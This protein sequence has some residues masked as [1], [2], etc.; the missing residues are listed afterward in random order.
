MTDYPRGFRLDRGF[1][2]FAYNNSSIDYASL[3]LVNALLIKKH[4]RTNAGALIADHNAM[5]HLESLYNTDVIR[6]AFDRIII[7][8]PTDINV[9]KRRFHDTRYTAFTDS[10]RNTN[11]ASVYD[12]SPFEET[13]L[14]D[15]DYLML[16]SSFDMV[17]GSVEDMMCNRHT[18]DL[19][20]GVDKFGFDNR[21]NEMSVPL[22]WA[23]AVYFRKTDRSRLIFE[24]MNFIKEN[25][26]YYQYLYRFNHS[27][28]FRND[29]AL[30]MALHMTN[31]LTEQDNMSALPVDHIMFSMEND[32]LHAFKDGC[33]LVT[34]EP[35]QGDF[36]IHNVDYNVHVM[37]KRA[38]LRLKDDIIAYALS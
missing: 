6:R 10:Y 36:R 9:G 35:N 2:M 21:F 14:I 15:S 33:C 38:I 19:D 8:E 34:S 31:N 18:R 25:Y 26:A 28:Y 29:Y 3:A 37:N 22:Y 16:D 13:L 24:L 27:G 30:S 7:D 1:V 20:H 32:E 5:D 17:W 12:L 23:T 11:R 4:L